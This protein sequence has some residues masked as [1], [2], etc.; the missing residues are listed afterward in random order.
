MMGVGI[1]VP[2]LPLYAKKLGA[3]A[4]EIGMIFSGFSIARMVFMPIVGR[5]SDRYGRKPFLSVGLALYS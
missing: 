3:T 5:L 2:L 4:F 1:I